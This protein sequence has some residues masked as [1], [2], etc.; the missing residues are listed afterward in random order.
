MK[1]QGTTFFLKIILILMAILVY[2]VGIIWLPGMVHRD[3]AAH[4]ETAYL[5]YYDGTD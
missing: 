3:A 5:S 1:R 2:A 4:P